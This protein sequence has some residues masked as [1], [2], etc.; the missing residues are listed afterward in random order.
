MCIDLYL[1]ISYYCC[2]FLLLLISLLVPEV[3]WKTFPRQN[4]ALEFAKTCYQV[5]KF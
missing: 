3:V 1:I 5:L 2:L 4:L